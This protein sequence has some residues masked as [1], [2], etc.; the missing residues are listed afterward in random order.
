MRVWEI[1]ADL[2]PLPALTD[3]I[4]CQVPLK[5]DPRNRSFYRRQ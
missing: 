1:P 4:R 3:F 5:F 2:P